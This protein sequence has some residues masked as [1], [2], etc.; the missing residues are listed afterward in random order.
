MGGVLRQHADATLAE[1]TQLE[2][3][4]LIRRCLAKLGRIFQAAASEAL[5]RRV[6]RGVR[7]D[8]HSGEGLALVIDD[9]TPQP[10]PATHSYRI[11]RSRL[12]RAHDDV[13]DAGSFKAGT[14]DHDLVRPL[15]YA[16]KQKAA[17]RGADQRAP[18]EHQRD[19]VGR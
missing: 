6:Q 1:A 16:L 2:G 10:P 3:A 18:G 7:H 5:R 11:E 15:R 17:A 9:P 12:V 19:V 14:G 4:G 13:L 8:L